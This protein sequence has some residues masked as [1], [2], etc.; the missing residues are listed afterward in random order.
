MN[1]IA[2]TDAPASNIDKMNAI[3]I[4]C[5]AIILFV[6]SL[7][8]LH[9]AHS[10]EAANHLQMS[11]DD[12]ALVQQDSEIMV[13]AM[14]N[15]Q[16][17]T[18]INKTHPALF[19]YLGGKDNFT[20]FL[21]AALSEIQQMDLKL[22]KSELLDPSPYY[23]VGNELLAIIPRVQIMQVQEQKI[24]SIGFLIAVKDPNGQFTYLDG[25]GLKNE[26]KVLWEMFPDLPTDLELPTNTTE[27]ID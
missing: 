24:K 4:P 7:V 3:R 11:D 6:F 17:S 16:S 23:R 19:P 25:S 10:R 21:E 27:M 5:I 8:T 14:F 9:S 1:T 12:F 20:T 2:H 15:G 26:P 13:N 22:I 18:F